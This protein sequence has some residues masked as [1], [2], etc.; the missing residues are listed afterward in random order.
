MFAAICV[1]DFALQA[2][3]RR[4]P[5]LRDHAVALIPEKVAKA[6]IMQ[7]TPAARALGVVPG[8]TPS[9]GL[10]RC[11]ELIIQP[12]LPEAE[13]S[14]R[15]A[16]FD[17]AWGISPFVEETGEGICTVA[18]HGARKRDYDCWLRQLANLHLHAR[19]G[20]APNADLALLAAQSASTWRE[21]ND[22]GQLADVS[23]ETLEPPGEMRAILEKWGIRT[24]GA[25][26]ALGRERLVERLGSAVL[27]LFDRAAGS[28]ERPLRCV[29]PAEIF[30]ESMEFEHEIETL[31]P[32]LF[33]LRRLLEQ[34]A[35]RLEMIYRVAAELT[36][37]FGL[38]N[39]DQS[40]RVFK[41]PSPTRDVDVLFRMV[42]THLENFH[43]EHPIV[44]LHLCARPTRST[45]Q[46]FGL[47][48]SALRDPNQFYETLAR[49]AA[50]V[51]HDRVGTPELDATH[52]PDAFHMVDEAFQT[53]SSCANASAVGLLLRRFRPALP[54]LVQAT[55]QPAF[56]HTREASGP[57]TALYGPMLL[58]GDWWNGRGWSRCEWDV[59]LGDGPLCRI[60]EEGGAWFL[61]G[62]YD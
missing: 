30:E 20:I 47:F 19:I 31:E 55:P 51:G 16:L 1:P 58:S 56:V 43:T 4:T 59:Q 37:R 17:C 50:L 52:R 45:R 12:R 29:A 13:R 49:L 44:S 35:L 32:L 62:V 28:L 41:I 27:Q 48:E 14:A 53:G 11:R 26:V 18:L 25:F 21:V 5:E 33:M 54:A 24:L 60:Y 22:P 8:M 57:V 42:Q 38:A 9:Q 36:L 39:G 2:L 3:L 6:C 61:E 40:Q 23:I 34:I 10:A 46:Q 15:A 7:L